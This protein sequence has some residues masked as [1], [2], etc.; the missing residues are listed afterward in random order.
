MDWYWALIFLLFLICLVA[1]GEMA[2]TRRRSVRAWVW[3][4]FAVGPLAL[5]LLLA[6]GP[7]QRSDEAQVSS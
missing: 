6:L 4:A 7:R 2:E 3:C 5:I 1:A